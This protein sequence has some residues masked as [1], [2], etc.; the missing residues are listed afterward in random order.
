MFAVGLGCADRSPQVVGP[1][2]VADGQ[3]IDSLDGGESG[4]GQPGSGTTRATSKPAEVRLLAK[5]PEAGS[6]APP[7]GV[8]LLAAMQRGE[9]YGSCPVYS[10]RVYEDGTVIY[11]G[12]WHVRVRGGRKT[13]LSAT[14]RDAL[15][16]AFRR[17]AR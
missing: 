6:L 17:S 14:E 4:D 15:R 9:C 13:R 12:D 1:R 5:S 3:R 10:I 16:T 8:P 7:R 11:R 2:R